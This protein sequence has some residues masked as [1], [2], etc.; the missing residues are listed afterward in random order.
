MVLSSEV[1]M[2]L[3][4]PPWLSQVL[5]LQMVPSQTPTPS[6]MRTLSQDVVITVLLTQLTK[7]FVSGKIGSSGS[8]NLSFLSFP[9]V[10]LTTSYIGFQIFQL[11]LI[12]F[13][14]IS[15]ITHSSSYQKVELK[16]RG[17]RI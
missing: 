16:P 8:V 9:L 6:V 11:P 1:S 13:C 7:V 12:Y 10:F 3:Q 17:R 15:Y 14:Q 4:S 2:V 5:H